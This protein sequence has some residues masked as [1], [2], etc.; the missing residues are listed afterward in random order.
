MTEKNN[1]G[2]GRSPTGKCIGWHALSEEE[3]QKK[4]ENYET[5]KNK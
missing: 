3:Y 4:K 2:C 5:N 1:C